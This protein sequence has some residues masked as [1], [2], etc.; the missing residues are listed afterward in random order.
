[1]AT[2]RNRFAGQ[3]HEIEPELLPAYYATSSSVLLARKYCLNSDLVSKGWMESSL[4]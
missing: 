2:E 4:L 3:F 1:M